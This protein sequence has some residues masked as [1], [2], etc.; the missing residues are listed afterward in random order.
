VEKDLHARLHKLYGEIGAVLNDIGYWTTLH[1]W[2]KVY[3]LATKLGNISEEIIRILETL[4]RYE[5]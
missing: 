4:G 3:Q 2:N 1:K 5:R